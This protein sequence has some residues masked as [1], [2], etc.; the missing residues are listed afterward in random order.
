MKEYKVVVISEYTGMETLHEFYTM[1]MVMDFIIE[2]DKVNKEAK[3]KYR[4]IIW[5]DEV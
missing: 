4:Y 5:K 3:L 2:L 1:D